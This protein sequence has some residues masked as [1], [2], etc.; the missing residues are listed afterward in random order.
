MG[1][2]F[3]LVV[4]V[5]I[6]PIL[7]APFPVGW[8]TIISIV[9]VVGIFLVLRAWRSGDLDPTPLFFLAIG[10]GFILRA[11]FDAAM[12]VGRQVTRRAVRG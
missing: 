4:A 3:L 2:L 8:R 11:L 6:P 7:L 12:Y 9:G 5:V 1:M 10:L